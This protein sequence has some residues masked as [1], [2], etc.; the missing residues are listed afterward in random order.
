MRARR[1]SMQAAT[2]LL[3]LG[4]VSATLAQVQ[5]QGGVVAGGGGYT[6]GATYSGSATVGQSAV[7]RVVGGAYWVASGF[8][9]DGGTITAV[10]NPTPEMPTE[11]A[12]L[13]NYPNPFNPATT[14]GFDLPNRSHV[15]LVVFNTLG[16]E[17]ATLVDGEVDAGR[18]E[19]TFEAKTLASGIY[20]YRIT[21]GSFVATRRLVVLR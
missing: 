15:L 5:L 11:Y 16:Q 7:G 13:Q 9:G 6:S 17:V 20:F 21:A 2:L 8:W 14:I 18:H 4:G 3:A 1:M 12:L 19:V 10:D